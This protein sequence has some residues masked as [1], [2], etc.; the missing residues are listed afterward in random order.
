MIDILLATYNGGKYISQQLDSLFGQT[1]QDFRIIVRDDGS[2][3]D[4]LKIVDQYCKAHP[5]RIEVV[6]DG[7]ACGS[8]KSN[9]FQLMRHSTSDYAMF[10]DQDDVWI[11]NKI[12]ITLQ[13]MKE[14]ERMQNEIPILVFSDLHVV[15]DNLGIINSSFMK[16]E[17]LDPRKTSLN[18]LLAQNVATGCT[19]M[20]NR[21]LLKTALKFEHADRIIMHDWWCALVASQ[22]GKVVYI[23]KPLVL[24]RQHHD[25][26]VGAKSGKSIDYIFN[27]IGN[28]KEV[29]KIIENTEIQ[30]EEFSRVFNLQG[31]VSDIYSRF[32]DFGR[33]KK[34]I[35]RI[36]YGIL[37][38]GFV[39]N[40]GL[41]IL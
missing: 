31:S 30:A 29:K 15:D 12:E 4:T 8:A 19:M 14:A 39:R 28:L 41:M 18:R 24:Y 26:A 23:D 5:G 10:C 17:N 25:N 34:K 40:V 36:R 11:D 27:M 6:M 38:N 3:D 13:K 7:I 22:F 21:E 20:I 35:Y 37:K 9:F 2:S 1:Y 16:Y 33:V 32:T